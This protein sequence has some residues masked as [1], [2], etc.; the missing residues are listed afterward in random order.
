MGSAGTDLGAALL[1]LFRR[2]QKLGTSNQTHL[3]READS[4]MIVHGAV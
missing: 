3:G 4:S 1:L 2:I